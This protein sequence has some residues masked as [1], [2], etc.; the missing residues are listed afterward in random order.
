MRRMAAQ[1]SDAEYEAF[2]QESAKE[3]PLPMFD[4]VMGR[5]LGKS[6][7]R[8]QSAQSRRGSRRTDQLDLFNE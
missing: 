1:M 4:L 7:R 6:S 8:S 3:I 2:R 5:I